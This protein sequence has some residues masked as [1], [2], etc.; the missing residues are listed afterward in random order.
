M[1]NLTRRLEQLGYEVHLKPR[2]V[3]A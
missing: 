3:A 2:P 1:G